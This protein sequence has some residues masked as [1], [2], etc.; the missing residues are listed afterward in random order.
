MGGMAEYLVNSS[1]SQMLNV[2]VWPLLR[3]RARLIL[4]PVKPVKGYIR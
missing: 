2:I 3:P 1:K 4:S